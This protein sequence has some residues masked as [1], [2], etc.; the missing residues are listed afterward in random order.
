MTEAPRVWRARLTGEPYGLAR[1][2]G[3]P[4]CEP[5]AW[6]EAHV[7]GDVCDA[8]LADDGRSMWRVEEP[9]GTRRAYACVRNRAVALPSLPGLGGLDGDALT[10]WECAT[11]PGAMLRAVAGVVVVELSV[12]ASIECARAVLRFV[13]LGEDRPR[14][15]V[16]AAERAVREPSP[17]TRAAARA[18]ANAADAAARTAADSDAAGTWAAA[19][20][21]AGAAAWESADAA[22]WAARA[23]TRA[24]ASRDPVDLARVVRGVIPTHAVYDAL[25][26]RVAP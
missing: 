13:P 1:P 12:L 7:D 18:A 26:R 11:D 10:A 15:A 21:S 16:E 19:A 24:A 6:V 8:V 17:E 9:D 5:A 20:E 2:A 25:V 23:A 4:P 14:L 3:A 22:A